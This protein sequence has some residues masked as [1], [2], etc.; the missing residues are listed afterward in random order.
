MSNWLKTLYLLLIIHYSGLGSGF[1]RKP[2]ALLIYSAL[3][4]FIM[5]LYRVRI[6]R[7]ILIATM[8]WVIYNALS[9]VLYG[10]LRGL[11]I[12]RYYMVILSSYVLWELYKEDLPDRFSSMIFYFALISIPL[13]VWLNLSTGSLVSIMSRFDFSYGYLGD[14]SHR[15]YLHSIVYSA[16]PTAT[17]VPRR[18]YGYCWEPGPYSAY[19]SLALYFTVQ[20]RKTNL[21][22]FWTLL[23]AIITT[24]ST[25][26]YVAMAVIILY[27]Y[28]SKLRSSYRVP[29]LLSLAYFLVSGY[30]QLDFMSSKISSQATVFEG[31]TVT[32]LAE[33]SN[34][35]QG[36]RF[37][38]LLAGLVSLLNHPFGLAGNRELGVDAVAHLVSGLGWILSSFGV[39]SLIVFWVFRRSSVAIAELF[40]RSNT[41][42][43]L[44]ICLICLAGFNF[45]G[46]PAFMAFALLGLWHRS[47]SQAAMLHHI[48]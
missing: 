41:N 43:Y 34:I 18:N 44:F 29:L 45:I 6:R 32:E 46:S 7:P 26:G 47:V 20:S 4:I 31:L 40:A 5:I 42:S 15:H 28:A 10:Q 35:H 48:H 13:W 14:Q 23:V 9:I 3:T 16:D 38:G 2:N 1:Y 17:A 12:L 39:F 33:V 30:T 27:P 36:G 37:A 24:F 25:T 8:I 19:L 11:F 22:R 21:I